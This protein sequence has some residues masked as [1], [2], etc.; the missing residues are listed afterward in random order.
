MKKTFWTSYQLN[1]P[2]SIEADNSK[3]KIVAE[4]INKNKPN[5]VIVLVLTMVSIVLFQ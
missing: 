5:K 1:K 3:K 4:Y 2:Y